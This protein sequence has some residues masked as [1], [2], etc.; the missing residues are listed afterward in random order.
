MKNSLMAKVLRN[1]KLDRDKE[2]IDEREFIELLRDAH[3]NNDMSYRE[4]S[5]LTG[6]PHT[7]IFGW[8]CPESKTEYA[9]RAR[10]RNKKKMV[11][12]K[13]KHCGLDFELSDR[14]WYNALHNN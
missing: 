12:I 4:L 13:C 3:E 8:L 1:T 5:E 11:T 6:I 9:E 14:E 2:K 10:A 7:T